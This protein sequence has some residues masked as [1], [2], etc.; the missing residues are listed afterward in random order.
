MENI[1]RGA[2]VY[3]G[4]VDASYWHRMFDNILEGVFIEGKTIGEAYL[5]ARNEDYYVK[6]GNACR[7]RRGDAFYALYGDPTFRPKWWGKY[8]PN[9]WLL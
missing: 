3:M 5:E 4:A 1:R 8:L 7:E 9:W 6:L 2:M